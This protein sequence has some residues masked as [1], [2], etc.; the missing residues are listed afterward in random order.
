[1][2]L[3]QR[4]LILDENIENKHAS[5]N[6]IPELDL[7][8]KIQ[9][10]YTIFKLEKRILNARNNLWRENLAGWE[11]KMEKACQESN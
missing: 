2:V 3:L 8:T 1:L 10:L 5:Q 7:L 6:A 4:N 9:L 11:N